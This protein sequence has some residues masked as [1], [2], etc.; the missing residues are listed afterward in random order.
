MATKIHPTAESFMHQYGFK[1]PIDELSY[2]SF[3]LQ[4]RNFLI[5]DEHDAHLAG[6]ASAVTV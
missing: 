4:M 5:T 3:L 1:T 6:P 2:R